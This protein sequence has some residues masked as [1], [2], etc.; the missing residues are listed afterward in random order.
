MV[1]RLESSHE[2]PFGF[3]VLEQAPLEGLHAAV[4]QE[5][6]GVHVL[7][8]P[9]HVPEWHASPVVQ[10]FPSLQ[11]V[12]FAFAGYTHPVAGTHVAAE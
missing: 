12:P 5:F 9:L 2:D 6:D 10:A 8:V 4:L 7:G 3:C 11:V 1:Q